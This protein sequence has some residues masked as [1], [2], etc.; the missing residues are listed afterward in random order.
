MPELSEM[1]R[2]HVDAVAPHVTLDDVWARTGGTPT[3]PSVGP[4]RRRH[5]AGLTV[6][7]A[8]LAAALVVALVIVTTAPPQSSAAAA[9][10]QAALVAAS[11]PSGPVAGTHQYLYYDETEGGVQSTAEWSGH[12]SV[13]YNESETL[14]TWV[15]PDGSGRQRITYSPD[16]VV[17][18]SQRAEWDD[19]HTLVIPP[20]TSDTAFPTTFPGSPPGGWTAC[21]TQQCAV[22]LPAEL[23][24]HRQ[25]PDPAGCPR[26]RH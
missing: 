11:R 5:R 14:E 13:L 6:A 20:T 21:H 25:V 4:R 8:A 17:L 12:S 10:N 19:P 16:T 15:A 23:P 7:A 24:R 3:A 1:I 2:D 18:P 9:L 26:A 22:G